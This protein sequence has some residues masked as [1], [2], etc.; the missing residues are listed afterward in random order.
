MVKKLANDHLS[1]DLS[2]KP[3]LEAESLT[4][5]PAVLGTP[6]LSILPENRKFDV[7]IAS[8]VFPLGEVDEGQ[9]VAANTEVLARITSYLDGDW[10]R[11]QE[12]T[13]RQ[14]EEIVAAALAQSGFQTT[15]T[16]HSGDE[17]RDVI[18]VR[19][20]FFSMKVVGSVKRYSPGR[21]V[22]Y[23]H[24]RAML[25][26]QEHESG[27]NMAFIATTSSFPPKISEDQ[28]IAPYVGKELVL[29]DGEA[30]QKWLTANSAPNFITGGNAEL[31][32]G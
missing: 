30:L 1:A 22:E 27:A 5:R 7:S 11:A 26:I 3:A 9:I 12:F 18:G 10:S 2:A 6:Q 21:T 15:L 25:W 17:G 4:I 20:G 31:R 32:K 14:W 16:P 13:A 24:M 28:F 23:D 29:I 19:E 8:V